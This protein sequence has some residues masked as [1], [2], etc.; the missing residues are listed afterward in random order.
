MNAQEKETY[1]EEYESV[2]QASKKA[3]VL[4]K[5]K[6][7]SFKWLINIDANGSTSNW[8]NKHLAAYENRGSIIMIANP[9]A[10]PLVNSKAYIIDANTNSKKLKLRLPFDLLKPEHF[11]T[12]KKK[13]KPSN[14]KKNEEKLSKED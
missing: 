3:G 13:K 11:K 12:K 9:Q 14:E 1:L 6:Y 10:Y 7:K 4:Q 8:K 2:L 5:D